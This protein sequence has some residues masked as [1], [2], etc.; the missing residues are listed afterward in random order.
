[1]ELKSICDETAKDLGWQ[2]GSRSL[3]FAAVE[4]VGIKAG[5]IFEWKLECSGI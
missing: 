3:G 2:L 4:E 1:M 5:K